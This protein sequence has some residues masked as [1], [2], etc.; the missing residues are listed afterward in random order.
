MLIIINLN[1]FISKNFRQTSTIQQLTENGEKV[2]KLKDKSINAVDTNR[3][4]FLRFVLNE[5]SCKPF[6]KGVYKKKIFVKALKSTR[7]S[8]CDVIISNLLHKP[9][10]FVQK[11]INIQRAGKARSQYVY[12]VVDMYLPRKLNRFPV[13]YVPRY[14]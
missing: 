10:C 5:R 2:S 11:N 6:P 12:I 13:L 4:F 1:C 7:F 14:L 3:L 8:V 9:S